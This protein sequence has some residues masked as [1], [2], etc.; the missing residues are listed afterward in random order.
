MKISKYQF[1]K[2]VVNYVSFDDFHE[3]IE[4]AISIY[5]VDGVHYVVI[6]IEKLKE[7]DGKETYVVFKLKDYKYIELEDNADIINQV[8]KMYEEDDC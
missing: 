3:A 8:L 5:K 1:D 2:D 6:C 4:D 7:D